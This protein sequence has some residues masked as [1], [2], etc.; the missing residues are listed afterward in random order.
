MEPRKAGERW[1][2]NVPANYS[3]SGK[4]QRLYFTTKAQARTRADQ[5]KATKENY[6]ASAHLLSASQLEDAARALELLEGSGVR[7]VELADKWRK[8]EEQRAKSITFREMIEAYAARGKNGRGRSAGY[9]GSIRQVGARM[10]GLADMLLC[11]ITEKDIE[12]ELVGVPASSRNYYLRI[13]RCAFNRGIGLGFCEKNPAH[14]V[15]AAWRERGDIEIYSP[16][17]VTK[18]MEAAELHP[19]VVPFYAVSFFAGIRRGEVL[20]MDWSMLDIEERGIRLPARVTKTKAGR[21]I[22]MAENLAAWLA[23]YAR[24]RGPVVDIT[25][26]QLRSIERKLRREAGVRTIKHGPRHCFAAY[27]LASTGDANR[28]MLEM[29]HTDFETTKQHYARAVRKR[30]AK[31][32]WA[33]V[34]ISR[35]SN[36]IPISNR[37]ACVAGA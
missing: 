1:M 16:D 19:E 32:F 33:I 26:N 15:E 22:E 24:A 23:P 8:E 28:V 9:A 18:I 31:K 2:L 37:I 7:L 5:L 35:A 21:D 25:A 17:E 34:P 29:G 4:R 3:S 27:L 30:D 6:G 36:V 11:D 12:R 10:Q 13:M 20:R 14:K